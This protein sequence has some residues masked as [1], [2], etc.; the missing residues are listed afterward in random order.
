M[1]IDIFCQTLFPKCIVDV[2]LDSPWQVL[3]GLL[4]LLGDEVEVVPSCVAEEAR[5]ECERDASGG[6]V[7]ALHDV[8]PEEVLGAAQAQPHGAR[9]HHRDEGQDLG[10]GEQV[11]DLGGRANV[12]AVHSGE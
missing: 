5:V 12:P 10:E 7:R 3:V 2:T 1:C 8:A 11:L 4:E 9:H 6:P